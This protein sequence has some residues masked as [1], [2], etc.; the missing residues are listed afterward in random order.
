[1]TL[2]ELWRLFPIQL[3]E[4]QACWADW[5]Q[6]EK[7]HLKTVLP[8]T[9]KVHH[10]GSTSLNGIWAKPIIDIL[11][12]LLNPAFCCPCYRQLWNRILGTAFYQTIMWSL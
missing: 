11:D 1:M 7:D 8:Y 9:V 10:I 2:E 4:P 5:Y 3:I 6:E 12:E